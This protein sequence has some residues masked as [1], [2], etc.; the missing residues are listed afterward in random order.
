[1]R[2]D[3]RTD[4]TKLKV[5]FRNIANVPKKCH[6]N[7]ERTSDA[8]ILRNVPECYVATFELFKKKN[9]KLYMEKP[10]R[11]ISHKGVKNFSTHNQHTFMNMF[12]KRRL[13]SASSTRTLNRK[14]VNILLESARTLLQLQH[15]SSTMNSHPVFMK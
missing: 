8:A 4:I 10:L 14:V 2:T 7:N 6:N 12:I 1:M 5:A 15:N 11:R 3:G 9:F 13:I